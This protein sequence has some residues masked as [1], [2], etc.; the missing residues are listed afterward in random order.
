[1]TAHRQL[2][3][4]FLSGRFNTW[5]D[6]KGHSMEIEE[7]DDH[8]IITGYGHALYC[9]KTG[10]TVVLFNDWRSKSRTTAKHLTQ[11]KTEAEADEHINLIEISGQFEQREI[12]SRRSSA[13]L[14]EVKCDFCNHQVTKKMNR[15]NGLRVCD[16]TKCNRRMAKGENPTRQ[17]ATV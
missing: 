12:K 5:N 7:K 10:G 4:N 1:M 14:E 9:L 6:R 17:K 3:Q 13:I 2:I 8:T 11:I 15:Q 16:K